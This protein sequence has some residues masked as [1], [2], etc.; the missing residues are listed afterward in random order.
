M[1][2]NENKDLPLASSEPATDENPDSSRRPRHGLD[3][4]KSGIALDNLSNRAGPIHRDLQSFADTPTSSK[5]LFVIPAWHKPYADALME[6]DGARLPAV[7]NRAERAILA[8]Y[9]S[10]C[11]CPI[12]FEESVDLQN[13]V[14]VLNQLKESLKAVDSP[15]HL[16]A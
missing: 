16:P 9:I 2:Q 6:S 12:S 13:A 3:S 14:A 4:S 5:C 15:R 8:R 1:D 11:D 10:V 7:I